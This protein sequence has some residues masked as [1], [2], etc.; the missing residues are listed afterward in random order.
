MDLLLSAPQ[1]AW[2]GG[3]GVTV[4]GLG[5]AL[6]SPF[7]ATWMALEMVTLSEVS[8]AEE[9]KSVTSLGCGI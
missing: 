6:S 7:A 1:K 4:R 5:E 9:G 8:Q 3:P 2:D